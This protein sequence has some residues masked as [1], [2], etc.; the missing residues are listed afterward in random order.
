MKIEDGAQHWTSIKFND[1]I[2]VDALFKHL[3]GLTVYGMTDPGEVLE[4]V[5]QM[6]SSDEEQWITSWTAMARR[7]QERAEQAE[8]ENRDVT[9][10][11]AYLRAST[12]WRASLLYFSYP[13]DPRMV[14]HCVNSADCYA[15]HLALSGYPGERI[16]IPYE[17]GFLP[18][19][20]YRSPVAP[21]NGPLL[22]IT[23]GRD[24][25]AEDARWVYDG[26]LKRGIHCLVYDGP[27]QGFAL[28]VNKLPFRPDWENVLG[29]VVD[30]ALT[31]PGVDPD[32][33]GVM[34][35]SFGGFLVTRAAAFDTRIKLCVPDPGSVS[36]GR[37]MTDRLPTP[38]RQIVTG[39]GPGAVRKLAISVAE[40]LPML[41]WLLRD[42]AWKH[43]VP[44][45]DVFIEL[46]KYDNTDIVE[47]I[48]CE[49]LVLNGAAEMTQDEPKK[50]F[51]AL[52]SPKE[53]L[54]FDEDTTAQAH[55]QMGS[56]STGTELLL[57]VIS[58][59]L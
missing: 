20:F 37:G 22:I 12:Y 8:R 57:D 1:H 2:M 23:P 3:M 17:G 54:Y 55:C 7:L 9:A 38:L 29:P 6:T 41:E 31:L 56:Y 35:M 19:H 27:G 49:M 44:K 25:W 30:H 53:Y 33:I 48:G 4:V 52:S 16:E 10:A 58:K 26:A 39:T 59:K 14:R 47:Q 32:R 50:L 24:T 18:G 21:E 34:G 28:R 36:W 5:V 13:E 45:S 51:A 46:A 43:D 15:R 42:Y 11:S 40:R